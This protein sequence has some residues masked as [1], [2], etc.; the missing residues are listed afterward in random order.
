MAHCYYVETLESAS[1]GDRIELTGAEARHAASVSRARVGQAILVG[2]GRGLM[3]EGTFASVDP[4]VVEARAVRDVPAAA[5]R[6]GLVQALAKG[7]RDELAVQAATELGV[8]VIMPWQADRSIVAW[9]GERGAKQLARWRTIVREAGKQSLRAHV[10]EVREPVTTAGLATLVDDWRVLVLE[11]T[12]SRSI[13]EV[14]DD[15]TDVLL[16]VGPEG[17]IADAEL[18]RLAAAEHVRMGTSVLRTSTAGPAAIAALS[19]ALGRW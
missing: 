19:I 17:G 18:E 7:D 4:V 10:P 13:A 6:I 5:P 15:G 2:N 8:D 9:K 1:V 14:A 16:V 11:P 3:V 12:A